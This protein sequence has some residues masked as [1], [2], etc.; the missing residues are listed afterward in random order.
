MHEVGFLL[1]LIVFFALAFDYINGFH[2]T[3]NAIA[4]VVST[5]VL[6]PVQAIVM[7]AVL[8]FAGA[9]IATRVAHTIASGIIETHSATETVVLAAICG[10]IVWNLVTW[11]LGIP[12]SSSHAL[13]G[14]LCGAGAA[15]AG[16]GAVQWNGL[17]HKVLIPL[18]ASPVVGFLFGFGLMALITW[19]CHSANP[20]RAGD[21]FRNM[22]RLSAA[23]MAFAHGQNDAQ[24]SMG[25]I[26]LAL[27]THGLLHKPNVPIWV[28]IACATTMALGTAAGGWRIIRT[29]G[30]KIMRLDPVNGFAA[31]TSGASV[32]LVSSYFGM[33]V[34][35]THVLAGSIFG[36]GA[37]KGLRTVRWTVAQRMVTAWVLTIPAA[38]TVGAITY[39]FLTL[40]HL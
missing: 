17:L 19:L 15:H 32:I 10:G 20:R 18:V 28:I 33:P 30:H 34:S 36:V 25:V 2:D 29:M 39:G 16:I 1:V 23:A 4:T 11:A 3:A 21:A 12:S 37:S 26:T 14:G 8:N 9:L 13:I 35:T 5:R 31:E 6:T 40:I 7:A 27:F 24:K 38:A 22:Q